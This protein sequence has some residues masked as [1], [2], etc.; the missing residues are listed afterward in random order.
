[1]DHPNYRHEIVVA[2]NV[3]R[4]LLDDLA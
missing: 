1:V 3:R 4:S 2:E